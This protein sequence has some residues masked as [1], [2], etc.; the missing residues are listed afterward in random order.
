MNY[1]VTKTKKIGIFEIET[2]QNIW[3]DEFLVLRSK[4][5]VFKCGDDCKIEAKV[6]SKSLSKNIKIEDYKKRLD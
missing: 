3:I 5:Y 2:P 1:F 4:M 6:L